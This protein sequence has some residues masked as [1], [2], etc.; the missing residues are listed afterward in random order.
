[1]PTGWRPADVIEK[2]PVE[3]IGDVYHFEKYNPRSS[4][5]LLTWSWIQMTMLLLLISYLFGNI[6]KIGSPDMFIYGAFVFLSVYAYTELMDRNRYSIVWET[7]K[8]ISGILIILKQGDWFGIQQYI[9]FA[10]Y[11]L[12]G[13]FI[14]ATFITGWF[15]MKHEKEDRQ[16]L[17]A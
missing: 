11:F 1:M 17:M 4:K 12:V 14:L 15:V 5:G 7:I 3:K 6:A 13:Y 16:V 2:Y 9:P 8:N 10:G